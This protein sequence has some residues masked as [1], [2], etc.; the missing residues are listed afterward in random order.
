M[1]GFYLK[2]QNILGKPG[3]NRSNN[4][5]TIGVGGSQLYEFEFFVFTNASTSGRIG[6]TKNALINSYDTEENPWLLEEEFYDMPSFQ[7]YQL[8][9]VP[10]NGNYEFTVVGASRGA[11]ASKGASSTVSGTISLQK[12]QKLWIVCGQQGLSNSEV[13]DGASWVVLSNN[14]EISESIP[15]FIAGGAGDYSFY[16]SEGANQNGQGFSN[17]QTTDSLDVS[18]L[19]ATGMPA[20][21]EGFGGTA[22]VPSGQN[23]GF[24]SGGGGFFSDG[25]WVSGSST[26]GKGL[27][28]FNGLVGGMYQSSSFNLTTTTGAGFGGGGARNGGF[29]TGGGG[30]YTGG[31]SVGTSNS[32]N[33][34]RSTG[35]SSYVS[36]LA[37]NVT[38]VLSS[39]GAPNAA[40]RQGIVQVALV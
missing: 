26:E 20:P 11:S 9:T 19:G 10:Q 38:R 12:N 13:G 35:G 21:T 6:P 34:R 16:G 14:G 7:G 37:Q 40:P 22:F 4:F 29:G 25:E 28:F 36:P 32:P 30:G 31:S 33:F 3:K 23:A 27:S 1:S 2:N 17:A 18:P 39:A 5:Q 15:L 24:V 8:W